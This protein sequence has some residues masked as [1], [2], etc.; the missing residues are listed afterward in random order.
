[1]G[2]CRTSRSIP[3]RSSPFAPSPGAWLH[4]R[5][6]TAP[7]AGSLSRAAPDPPSHHAQQSHSSGLTFRH[8]QSFPTTSE[9]E[10]SEGERRDPASP[11]QPT[12]VLTP[13][14]SFE[15]QIRLGKFEENLPSLTSIPVCC[16]TF[17]AAV[18]RAS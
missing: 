16:P 14:N 9:T 5:A 10:R 7:Y 8:L 11:A 17:R 1:M 15:T 2:P 13:G 3:G 12:A 4:N 18:V 6:A